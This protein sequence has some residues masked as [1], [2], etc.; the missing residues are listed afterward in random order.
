M[1]FGGE[2][3]RYR[4]S[5][6]A[7]GLNF[8]VWEGVSCFFEFGGVEGRIN[9]E[10]MTKEL[11]GEER[12]FDDRSNKTTMD[13]IVPDA[14]CTLKRKILSGLSPCPKHHQ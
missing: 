3:R 10:A 12:W 11:I 9:G 4:E 1:G 2:E 7:S 14:L 8:G 5:W 6:E 13:S